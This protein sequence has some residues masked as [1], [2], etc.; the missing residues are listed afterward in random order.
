M[1][2]RFDVWVPWIRYVGL[3]QFQAWRLEWLLAL[4]KLDGFYFLFPDNNIDVN[5]IDV[6]NIE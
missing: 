2:S 5:N 4:Y 6:D 1:Y 3:E